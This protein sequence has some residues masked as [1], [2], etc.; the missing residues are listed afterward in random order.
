MRTEDYHDD[1]RNEM[2]DPPCERGHYEARID[3][4]GHKMDRKE[5]HGKVEA[6]T[7]F[8]DNG[9]QQIRPVLHQWW[10]HGG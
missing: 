4:A 5:R 7:R 10:G 8:F 2:H 9:S 1:K 6:F 3:N